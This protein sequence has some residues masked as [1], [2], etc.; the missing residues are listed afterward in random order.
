MNYKNSL[1]KLIY[2]YIRRYMR[3]IKYWIKL[4]NTANVILQTIYSLC[5]NDSEQE[6][7]NWVSKLKLF[8]I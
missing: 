4:S 1:N 7:T 5:L 2:I 6:L 8:V 3:I